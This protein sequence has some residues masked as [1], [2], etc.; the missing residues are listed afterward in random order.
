MKRTYTTPEVSVV[1]FEN[2]DIVTNSGGDLLEAL[3]NEVLGIGDN[4]ADFNLFGNNNN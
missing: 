3:T 1:L 2:E 4:T